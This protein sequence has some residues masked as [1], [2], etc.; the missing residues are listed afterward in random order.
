MKKNKYNI[1]SLF[2][3]IATVAVIIPLETEYASASCD[4][5]VS[6]TNTNQICNHDHI[7]KDDT[8]PGSLVGEECGECKS[9]EVCVYRNW[10]KTKVTANFQIF[11]VICCNGYTFNECA[12]ETQNEKSV[13]TKGRTF[14]G[15]RKR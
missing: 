13:E 14:E 15:C 8:V 7:I 6:S 3:T 1:T 11:N 12:G 2:V 4:T 10:T 9:P 5:R